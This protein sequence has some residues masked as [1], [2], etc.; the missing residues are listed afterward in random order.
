MVTPRQI[1][2]WVAFTVCSI[3]ESWGP[4]RGRE[5]R[6]EVISIIV[7]RLGKEGFPTHNPGLDPVELIKL[8]GALVDAMV[9]L[10]NFLGIFKKEKEGKS[11]KEKE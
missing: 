1:L 11:E 8:I 4:K 3:E 10:L 2:S 6:G 5:K 7:A 9:A